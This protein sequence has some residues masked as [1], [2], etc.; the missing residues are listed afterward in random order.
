MSVR[1]EKMKTAA[2]IFSARFWLA[3]MLSV[4]LSM[5]PAAA[6]IH[7]LDAAE[8]ACLDADAAADHNEEQEDADQNDG[9]QRPA[10]KH[11]THSCGPCH[12]HMASMN[13]LSLTHSLHATLSQRPGADEHVPYAGPFGLYR[14]PR[15]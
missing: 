7:P 8:M 5:G 1:L 4:T 14:P 11:H 13:G 10:H 9:E 3:I 12:L 15:A 2:L 6:D